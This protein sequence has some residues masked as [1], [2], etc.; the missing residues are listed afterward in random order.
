MLSECLTL[1]K[2]LIACEMYHCEPDLK[3]TAI[4]LHYTHR[5]TR[6]YLNKLITL[7]FSLLL[8]NVKINNCFYN[9]LGWV[10]CKLGF[11]TLQWKL[12]Q[13]EHMSLGEC[14]LENRG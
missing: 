13:Y 12:I 4:S 7:D 10:E 14:Q 6:W 3:R 2:Q 8:T 5:E 1:S 9:S 11:C